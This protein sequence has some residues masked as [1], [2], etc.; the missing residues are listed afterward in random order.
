M[1]RVTRIRPFSAQIAEVARRLAVDA[2]VVGVDRQEQRILRQRI[3]GAPPLQQLERA[4][5][6]AGDSCKW[7]TGM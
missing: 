7:S 2:K 3:P 4:S 5:A 6:L 1:V